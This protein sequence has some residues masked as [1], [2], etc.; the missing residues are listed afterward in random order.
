MGE[1]TLNNRCKI[2]TQTDNDTFIGLKTD[3]KN[4]NV[5]FP[6]GFNLSD[7]DKDIRQDILKLFNILKEF[8][9]KQYPLMNKQTINKDIK[10]PINA[11][12]NIINYFIENGYYI[13][14]YPI[15]KNGCSGKINWKKT[16]QKQNPLLQ[17]DSE[18]NRY[19]PIYTK[20]IIKQNQPNLNK[21]ITKINKYCVYE[22][23]EKIG[24]LFTT[25][26][27]PKEKL[28]NKKRALIL[29][30]NKLE[31][32]FNDDKKRLFQS[33][34]QL[35]NF[36][37]FNSECDIYWGT[38][39]FEY[40]W[41]KM[42]DEAF[43][44]KDKEKYFPR[45]QWELKENKSSS[46]HPLQPDTIMILDDKFFVIDAKYYKY[47]ITKNPNDLPNASSINKQI[48]YGDYIN[49]KNIDSNNIYNAFLIPYNSENKL[50]NEKG[51]FI[52]IGESVG[53]WRDN[54]LKYEHIQGILVDTKFLME[55][56]SNRDKNNIISLAN[57]IEEKFKT[58]NLFIKQ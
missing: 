52:N 51:K 35:I 48:T 8:G 47:G 3:D 11:Y 56:Y 13:E 31:N 45:A 17:E 36:V 57:T 12:L 41:E 55:I 44:I 14:K 32:T 40:I 28:L 18:N 27:P 22:S 58:N 2:F 30:Q 10:F 37:D 29:L 54:N 19:S 4:S 21:E 16:I 33:M 20:F 42:I 43:G 53:L 26:L 23:F 7:S 9:E 24:W 6:I 34:I 39:T 25:Y 5:F 46:L 1:Y 38:D 50:F 49:R 15:Y